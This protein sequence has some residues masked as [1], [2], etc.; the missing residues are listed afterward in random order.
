MFS[1]V[2]GMRIRR[3]THGFALW[4]TRLAAGL[5]LL[6]PVPAS[7]QLFLASRPEPPFTIGPLMIR[8]RVG[9]GVS[10]A[11]VNVLWSL[12][13]PASL[14]AAD[15][16]QDL[17]LLWPGEVE[18]EGNLGKP[19]PALD[20]YVEERG[21]SVIGEG[22]V[23]LF[24]QSLAG[25]G[26]SAGPEAQPG[27]APFVVFVQTDGALGLSPPGTLIRIPWTARLG[28]RGWLMDLRM[29]A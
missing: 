29:K 4:L 20:R 3:L 8:A 5:A 27:G 9:E 19:D 16:A 26:G 11:T 10:D 1:E 7:A 22:R 2:A 12:V 24:A 28:D 13:I 6:A 18:G 14:R 15:I 21:F 23:A 25:S 17:Y